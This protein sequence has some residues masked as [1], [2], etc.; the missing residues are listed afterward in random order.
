MS[1]AFPNLTGENKMLRLTIVLCCSLLLTG[2]PAAA[3]QIAGVEIPDALAPASG[4][5]ELL[6]NGAGIRKKFFMDIYIGALYLP[7]RTPDVRAIL[8]DTGPASV[9]MYFMR[10]EVSKDKITGGWNDGLEKNLSKEDMQA[11]AAR[12]EQFNSYFQTVHEGDT[13]RIDYQPAT[14]TTVRINGESRGVVTG[15]DFFRFL[16]RVWLGS[17]PVSKSLKQDMLGN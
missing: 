1:A 4:A 2:L 16:L 12:L 6:L 10:G 8:S 7:A 13:I 3:T 17:K 14:G 5:P 9:L 11:I 15:N